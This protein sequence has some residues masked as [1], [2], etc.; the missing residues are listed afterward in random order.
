MD[1]SI[2]YVNWNCADE[3]RDS[4]A[5]VQHWTK[6]L[7]YELIVVDNASKEGIS[8]LARDDITLIHNPTNVGFAAGCNIGAR[9]AQ[10]DFLVFLNP[11]TVLLNDVLGCLVSFLSENQGVGCAGPMILE[12]DGSIHYGAARSFP[13]ITN[14]F[15]EHT[16]LTFK[17]QNSHFAGRP[18]YSYWD[19]QSTRPVNTLLGACM[20]FQ[21]GVFEMVG[22]FDENF[23]LYYEEVDLCKRTSQAGYQVWYVHTCKILHEGHKS[24]IK[25]YGSIDPMLLIYFESAEKYFKKHH[26][27]SYVFLW[28]LM[29]SGIYLA[30]F[31]YKRKPEHWLFFKWGIGLV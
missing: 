14:E 4:I 19:H 16:T 24:V 10:G 27:R 23:F 29:F 26:G 5:S 22:G 9:K 21:R 25:E 18:Y 13:S 8:V 1:V 7:D 31:L 20:M 3:I 15:L 11:D 28:R 30:R 12:I 17:F 6:D 2:I